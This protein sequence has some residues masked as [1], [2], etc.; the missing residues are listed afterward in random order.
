MS[1]SSDRTFVHLNDLVMHHCLEGYKGS[2]P[3]LRAISEGDN[4]FYYGRNAYRCGQF[5]RLPSRVEPLKESG[6][7]PDGERG[8]FV[9]YVRGEAWD[10]FRGMSEGSRFPEPWDETGS[11]TRW[12][13]C[14]PILATRRV[15]KMGTERYFLARLVRVSYPDTSAL[16]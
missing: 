12:W 7:E 15:A 11:A 4:W 16:L 9:V 1:T 13:L 14:F 10:S 5:C 2:Q 6:A 8:S 3:S